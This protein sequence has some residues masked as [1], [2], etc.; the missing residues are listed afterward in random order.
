MSTLITLLYTYQMLIEFW[1]HLTPHHLNRAHRLRAIYPRLTD[2]LDACNDSSMFQHH[3]I[4]YALFDLLLADRHK[5]DVIPSK[6]WGEPYSRLRNRQH[7][8]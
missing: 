7:G 4:T 5:P 3:H 8:R 1:Y 6:I 2:K